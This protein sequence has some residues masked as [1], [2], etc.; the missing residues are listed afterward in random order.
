MKF[1]SNAAWKEATA[2]VSANREVLLVLAGVFFMLPGLAFALFL[3]PPEPVAGMKPAQLM[4][5]MQEYYLSALPYAIPMAVLQMAGSLAMLTLFTDRTRPTVGDAIRQGFVGVLP[6]IGAQ[7]LLG[8]GIGLVGGLLIAIVAATGMPALLTLAII[9][10]IAAI[11]YLAIR[12]VL[13]APA[14]AVEG[15]GNPVAALK[16]SWA[17]TSGNTVRIALF[18]LL[19]VVAFVVITIMVTSIVGVIFALLLGSAAKTVVAIFSS[20]LGAAFTLYAMATVASVHR[21]LAGP[22]GAAISRTFE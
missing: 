22:S 11:I 3:P 19:L 15:I 4:G 5:M 6:Y 20:A 14:I 18:F 21:Q 2:A 7:L 10:L 8:L 17:L 16:R 13:V 9:I 1:D 12:T